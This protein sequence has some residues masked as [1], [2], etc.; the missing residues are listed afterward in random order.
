MCKYC[1]SIGAWY[2]QKCRYTSICVLPRTQLIIWC[3]DRTPSVTYIYRQSMFP[4]YS[5]YVYDVTLATY[6]YTSITYA[7]FHLLLFHS[8]NITIL[9]V[10]LLLHNYRINYDSVRTRLS[11]SQLLSCYYNI[12]LVSIYYCILLQNAFIKIYVRI[13]L[14]CIYLHKKHNLQQNSTI[15]TNENDI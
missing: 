9:I 12:F 10:A 1:V 5:C 15:V 4:V 11:L 6:S 8:N 14:T 7:F 2:C 13:Y 3:V